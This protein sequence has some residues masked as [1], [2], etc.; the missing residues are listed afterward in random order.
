MPPHPQV[1]ADTPPQAGWIELVRFEPVRAGGGAVGVLSFRP[2]R[3]TAE[4]QSALVGIQRI[5][6]AG[7]DSMKWVRPSG[8]ATPGV[9][10]ARLRKP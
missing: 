3:R 7:V 6:R 8:E 2:R 10:Q 9:H 5:Q 4:C 1:E